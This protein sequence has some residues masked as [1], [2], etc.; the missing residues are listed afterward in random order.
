MKDRTSGSDYGL[1]IGGALDLMLKEGRQLIN[2]DVRYIWGTSDV[3]DDPEDP[4][5]IYNG[6]FQFLVGWG[7]SL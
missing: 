3:G 7:F 6:G 1:V 2:F 5:S 4:V